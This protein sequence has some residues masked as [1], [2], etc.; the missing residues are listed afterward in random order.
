MNIISYHEFVNYKESTVILSCCIKLVDYYLS[1]SFVIIE[2]NSS[3]LSDVPLHAKQRINAEILH[4]N[5][6]VMVCYREIPYA[7]NTL[8]IINICSDLYRYF[9][10]MYYNDKGDISI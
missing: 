2:N 6:F 9:V 3:A 1:T 5:E 4:K 7:T 10:S 8:K